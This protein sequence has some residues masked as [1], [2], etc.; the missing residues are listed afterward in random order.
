MSVGLVGILLHW[1][2][3]VL[4]NARSLYVRVLVRGTFDVAN[5]LEHSAC[6]GLC[7]DKSCTRGHCSGLWLKVLPQFDF[8]R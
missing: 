1:C 3:A 5:A 4:T 8:F 6:A 2:A 7:T